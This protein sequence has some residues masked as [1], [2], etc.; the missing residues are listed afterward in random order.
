[1]RLTPLVF[2]LCLGC[3]IAR[4]IAS[5]SGA[6]TTPDL[7]ELEAAPPESDRLKSKE[8]SS[9]DDDIQS[10]FAGHQS[11]RSHIQLD[12]PMYRPGDTI[13]VKSWTV[14]T[15]RLAADPN[16]RVTLDLINPRGQTVVAKTVQQL[17][18]G[19]SN[20]FVLP[21]DAPGGKWILRSTAV[22]GEVTDR[23]FIV[24]S[25]TPPRIQ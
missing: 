8:L 17:G 20:D 14:L 21:A 22:S 15:Q 16:N 10:W 1:M 4:P 9:I 11:R 13:W 7:Q 25:Y 3:A 19:A 12:R 23:P 24:S 18:G 5:D 2:S 6:S